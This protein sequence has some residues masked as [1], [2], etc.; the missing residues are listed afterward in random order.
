M[1]D[2]SKIKVNNTT[3]SIK[4]SVARSNTTIY[5]DISSI[6]I[7]I[8][9]GK[10]ILLSDDSLW[11]V[12]TST[13]IT[14]TVNGIDIIS[15]GSNKIKLMVEQPLQVDYLLHG[16][17]TFSDAVTR[18]FEL[19]NELVCSDKTYTITSTIYIPD[20]C[21]LRGTNWMSTQISCVSTA[22][23]NGNL[24]GLTNNY[25][26][27]MKDYSTI[28]DLHFVGGVTSNGTIVLMAGQ[29]PNL[30]HCF[31]DGTGY[32]AIVRDGDSGQLDDS[33]QRAGGTL[34]HCDIYGSYSVGIKLTQTNDFY[35]KDLIIQYY[36]GI[37]GIAL[38]DKVQAVCIDACDVMEY[39]YPI[40]TT[41]ST[42]GE[43]TIPEHCFFTNCMFD[44]GQTAYISNSKNLIFTN[45]WFSN[46][47]AV[48]DDRWYASQCTKDG[49]RGCVIINSNGIVFNNTTFFKCGGWGCWLD[50]SAYN[51]SF[52]GCTFAQNN[53]SFHNQENQGGIITHG[54][55]TS[56]VGCIFADELASSSTSYYGIYYSVNAHYGLYEANVFVGLSAPVLN[57]G[58]YVI[59]GSSNSA[60]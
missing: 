51:C 12:G 9:T 19:S 3:Y 27:I 20:N 59:D 49:G 24:I 45:C 57:N 10:Y 55:S 36:N 7:N 54:Y 38:C 48:S 32:H 11:Y 1:S 8:S 26:I 42:Y 56:V 39:G 29:M 14:D 30:T 16:G 58:S 5:E 6:P 21:T 34:T 18:G 37:Y 13:E 40:F 23:S 52:N 2:I 33:G 50:T 25:N 53:Y 22:D 35:I 46:G 43:F 15:V 41:A 17:A 31:F 60:R 4:D 28:T 47:R 44:S